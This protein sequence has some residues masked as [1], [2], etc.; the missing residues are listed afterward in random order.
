MSLNNQMAISQGGQLYFTTA[1]INAQFCSYM[2][3]RQPLDDS[4]IHSKHVGGLDNK[5]LIYINAV[6]RWL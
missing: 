5:M 3:G 1:I 6:L 2:F 4:Q